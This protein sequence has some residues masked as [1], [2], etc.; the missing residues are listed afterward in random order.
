MRKNFWRLIGVMVAFVVIVT[1]PTPA[2]VISA[3]PPKI[4]VPILMYHAVSNPPKDTPAN[5]VENWLDPAMFRCQLKWLQ[6]NKFTSI[7]PDDLIDAILG[8]KQLPQ[9][10]ILLT[11]DDGYADAWYSVVPTLKEFG[12][13]IQVICRGHKPKLCPTSA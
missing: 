2:N 4:R 10:P 11:F 12:F 5:W 1:L 8:K 7:S 13:T 9:N 3:T 6:K